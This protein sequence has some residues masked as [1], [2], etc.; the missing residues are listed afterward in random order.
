MLRCNDQIP[1]LF[2]WEKR[3]TASRNEDLFS[4]YFLKERRFHFSYPPLKNVKPT[5][6]RLYLHIIVNMHLAYPHL[7]VI[8]ECF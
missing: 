6:D 5:T 8:T 7:A 3:F 1:V 4:H 2:A